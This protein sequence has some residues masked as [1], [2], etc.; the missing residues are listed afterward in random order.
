LKKKE[1]GSHSMERDGERPERRAA[2]I[3]EIEFEGDDGNIPIVS[4]SC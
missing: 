4:T 2:I 1:G 3:S